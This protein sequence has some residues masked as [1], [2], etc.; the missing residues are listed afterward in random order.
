MSFSYNVDT[1]VGQSLSNV[2]VNS[3]ET[4][5]DVKQLIEDDGGPPVDLNDLSFEGQT[6]N[7]EDPVSESGVGIGSTLTVDVR[8]G[9][10]T[11]GMTDVA[12]P[13]PDPGDNVAHLRD[14]EVLNQL[15]APVS[16]GIAY[17]L[18]LYVRGTIQWSVQFRDGGSSPIGP[19][20]TG[21]A[22]VGTDDPN[23][24]LQFGVATGDT[25]SVE[26]MITL[27]ASGPATIFDLVSFRPLP[28]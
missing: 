17:E 26:A 2:D 9:V 7:D 11:Y 12:E 1:S 24:T 21:T 16:A 23:L 19:P 3:A 4:W 14:G 22:F 5:L 8:S 10:I 15:V 18:A 13:P 28:G 27:V 25:G 20:S 6:L